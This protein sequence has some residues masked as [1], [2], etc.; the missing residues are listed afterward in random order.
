MTKTMNWSPVLLSEQQHT[1][2][3]SGTLIIETSKKELD[4]PY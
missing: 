1:P 3:A 4:K 2:A